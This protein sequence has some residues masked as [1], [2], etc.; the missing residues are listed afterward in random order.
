[1]A[2]SR[3]TC[4]SITA[5]A[6]SRSGFQACTIKIWLPSLKVAYNDGYSMRE[7]TVILDMVDRHREQLLEPW[8]EY[9]DH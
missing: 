6:R 1:M 5:A 7:V 8:R 9:F 3:R 4:T 2:T